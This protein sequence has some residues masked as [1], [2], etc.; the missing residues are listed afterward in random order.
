M[1]KSWRII[2]SGK[3]FCNTY[4]LNVYVVLMKYFLKVS[5]KNIWDC[6]KKK[7]A[8]VVIDAKE[9]KLGLIS[10][11]MISQTFLQNSTLC[12]D[13]R[14]FRHKVRSLKFSHHHAWMTS[15]ITNTCIST[16]KHSPEAEVLASSL[17]RK[18]NHRKEKW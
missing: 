18:G 7:E 4:R 14:E 8:I 15:Q 16:G 5:K 17:V 3:N 11:H 1:K 6:L 9:Q 12:T 10:L 13:F 2:Y